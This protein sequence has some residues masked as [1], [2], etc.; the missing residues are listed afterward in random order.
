MWQQ[1]YDPLGSPYACAFIAAV[2]ILIFLL[3]L[4]LFKLKGLTAS[5]LSLAAAL[6]VAAAV[7]GMPLQSVLAAALFG[8]LNGLWPIGY[9]VLMAVWLYRL[10][11]KSGKFETIRSS[12]ST[13]SADQRIQVILIAFCFGAFLEGVAGFGVPIAICAALLVELG[14]KPIKAAM[15]C[16]IANAASGAYGAI[17]IPVLVGA[18]QGGVPLADLSL[19]MIAI[20]QLSTLFI[21]ALLVTIMDGTRGLRQ[22]WPVVLGIG[23][24]F[25]VS[26]S[27]I[28]FWLGPE[29]VD[30]VPPLVSMGA[31]ALFMRFWR[32]V[33]IYREDGG[34]VPPPEVKWRL[35]QVL[36]AWSPFYVL[37]VLVL[38]WSLPQFKALFV[39]QGLLEGTVRH[40]PIPSLDQVVTVVPPIVSQPADLR[41]VWHVALISAPGTAIL[42]ASL[43]TV[44]FAATLSWR[45]ACTEFGL[46]VKQLWRPIAMICLIMAV[47]Y[48][49][50][51][52]GGSSSI[53]LGMAGA[54]GIFPLLSPVIGWLGVFITGSVV[55]SNTLFANLQVITATQIDVSTSLMVAAN[56]SGGVMGKLISPQS[57][58]IAAVAVGQVGQEGKIMRMTL[59]YSLGLLL[60]VSLWTWLLSGA[61]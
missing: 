51:F 47:A 54:G 20:V 13:I 37:T 60:Y 5:G 40:W 4:T 49:A 9:I 46:T 58:A 38:L 16:L 2:P 52:S 8:V 6:V 41:A 42:L 34:A 24:L 44:L 31:L 19:K 10:A 45:A 48:I 12:I 33:F 22:T 11:V 27:A 29:L 50:N 55:N 21:P 17:G 32:P 43:V 3:G 15:L 56:T 14:F 28:L 57:I 1:N 26:Q 36:S 61:A 23:V 7:F 35:R 59:G 25:S 53:G 39:S 18:Q 30:I